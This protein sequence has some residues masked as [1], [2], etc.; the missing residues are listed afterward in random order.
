MPI[1]GRR[2]TTSSLLPDLKWT[3]VLLLHFLP[4]IIMFTFA[5]PTPP[6]AN[7]KQPLELL[8]DFQHLI[9]VPSGH[10]T[11][12]RVERKLEAWFKAF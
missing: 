10:L 12:W 3:D 6:F 2:K 11:K 9:D 1:R 7:N 5:L 8:G 4:K